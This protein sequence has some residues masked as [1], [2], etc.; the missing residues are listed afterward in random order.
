MKNSIGKSRRQLLET[1]T[2]AYKVYIDEWFDGVVDKK[3]K[4]KSKKGV[5]DE[6]NDVIS[7]L[8]KLLIN[9]NYDS[10]V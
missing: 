3:T 1:I 6:L 5:A 4:Q 10:Y 8:S 2:K 9:N 7:Q